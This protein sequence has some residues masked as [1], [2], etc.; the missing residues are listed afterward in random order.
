VMTDAAP[1][2]GD[3]WYRYEDQ[4]VC[5][6]S[7]RLDLHE[8]KVW[9]VT[10][11]GVWLHPRLSRCG[12]SIWRARGSKRQ[13]ACATKEEAAES[14]YRRKCSQVSILRSKS[15]RAERVLQMAEG[16]TGREG[17]EPGGER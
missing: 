3:V 7:V 5:D 8:Y 16:L 6:G 12:L 9:G 17:A 13:F 15:S 11:C 10:P 1:E 2:P 14:F 4:E